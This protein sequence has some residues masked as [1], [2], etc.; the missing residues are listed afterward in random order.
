LELV[1][2]VSADLR[3]RYGLDDEDVRLLGAR[4]ADNPWLAR[5]AEKIA[6]ADRFTDEHREASTGS[7][8]N[9]A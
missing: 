8:S 3:E 1:Q 2:R 5:P 6:F 9:G 4:L 7:R